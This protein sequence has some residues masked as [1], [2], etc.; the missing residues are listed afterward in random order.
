MS[1]AFEMEKVVTHESHDEDMCVFKEN[2]I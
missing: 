2:I 1:M